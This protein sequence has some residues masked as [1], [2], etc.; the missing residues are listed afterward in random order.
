M[1][2]TQVAEKIEIHFA[3]SIFFLLRK[4]CRLIQ[5]GKISCSGVR[6]Q[7]TIWCMRIACWVP[8]THTLRLCNTHYFPQQ[9]WLHE[10]ASM[11]PHT[12][13]ACNIINLTKYTVHQQY[14]AVK[15]SHEDCNSFITIDM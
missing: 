14:F 7:M 13:T 1:F 15:P 5:C 12:Y 4:S 9:H 11:L 3:F 2:Q 6:T 8:K 10:R